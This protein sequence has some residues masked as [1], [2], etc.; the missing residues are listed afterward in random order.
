MEVIDSCANG[1]GGC[2]H[3]CRQGDAR[4]TCSCHDGYALRPD[5]KSCEGIAH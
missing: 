5:G 1:N 2:E 3:V 4:T